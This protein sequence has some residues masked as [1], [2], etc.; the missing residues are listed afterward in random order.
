MIINHAKLAAV[1][2]IMLGLTIFILVLETGCA[3]IP[4]TNRTESGT[5]TT[6]GTANFYGNND[7]FEGTR[8]ANGKIFHAYDPYLAAQQT[9]PLGTKVKVT[10]LNNNKFI[11][12]LITDRIGKAAKDN[13]ISLSVAASKLLGSKESSSIKVRV[14]N[15][16]APIFKPCDKRPIIMIMS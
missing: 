14:D 7:G 8:M 6:T 10:N 9:L 12:V 1:K 11:Y 4:L 2:I 3:S 15:N 13:I 16:V 5:Y